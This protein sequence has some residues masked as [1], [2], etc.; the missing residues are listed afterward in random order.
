MIK[1]IFFDIDGTLVSFGTHRIPDNTKEALMALKAK[2]IK[3]FIATGRSGMLM[4]EVGGLDASLFDGVITF[5]GQ[6]CKVDGETIYSYPIPKEDSLAGI[7]FFDDHDISCIF[8]GAGFVEINSHNETALVIADLLGMRLP[9]P[10]DLHEVENKETIQLIFF[11][12]EEQE[13]KLLRVM[14][15]CESTR[16]HPLFTDIIPSGGG[17]HIG[18]Q[19]VLDH[20][21][22]SREESM[23]FGDGDNDITMIRHAGIGVAMGNADRSVKDAADYVTG[24]VDEDGI[25]SALRHFG[26]L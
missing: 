1:A 6:H 18:M 12:D 14:P 5:N 9:S 21:G 7:G 2:G 20:F 4:K 17:K 13:K 10:I 11:G 22:I 19:K 16:W 26:V 8:E 3:I 15:S 23:A 24:S 25:G